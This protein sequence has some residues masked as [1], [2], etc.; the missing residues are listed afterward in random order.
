MRAWFTY[1]K[2]LLLLENNTVLQL[3]LPQSWE[4]NIP[5][6]LRPRA[7]AL[8]VSRALRRQRRARAAHTQAPGRDCGSETAY[9]QLDQAATALSI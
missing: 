8:I 3:T 4:E 5:A 1:C 2:C 7:G 6:L 9:A